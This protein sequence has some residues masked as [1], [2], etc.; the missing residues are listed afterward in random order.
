MG[1]LIKKNGTISAGG[2]W[3]NE[4]LARNGNAVECYGTWVSGAAYWVNNGNN[5]IQSTQSVEYIDGKWWFHVATAS[6]SYGFTQNNIAIKPD[7]DYTISALIFASA[8]CSCVYHATI[9]ATGSSTNM[10]ETKFLD[11]TTTPTIF[12]D[13]F[14]SKHIDS[15]IVDQVSVDISTR[16]YTSGIDVYFTNFKVEEG[17]L[18]TLW[19]PYNDGT[20]SVGARCGFFEGYNIS[21]IGKDYIAANEFYEY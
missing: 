4:N 17:K 8:P 12:T 18:A 6:H 1:V 15:Y 2:T 7:T 14:N 19:T 16:T 9:E 21:S 5:G 20:D 3:N 10:Q 11:I 13:T